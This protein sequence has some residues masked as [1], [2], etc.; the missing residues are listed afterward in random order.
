MELDNFVVVQ[1]DL[2]SAGDSGREEGLSLFEGGEVVVK[3]FGLC[4]HHVGWELVFAVLYAELFLSKEDIVVIVDDALSAGFQFVYFHVFV[5]FGE[6]E[7]EGFGIFGF[8]S[9]WKSWRWKCANNVFV[10]GE[11]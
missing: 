5:L 3:F 1:S 11:A 7:D 6:V 8:G 9:E 10:L 4:W 2:W